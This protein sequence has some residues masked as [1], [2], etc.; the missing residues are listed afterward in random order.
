MSGGKTV[1]S[2]ANDRVRDGFGREAF[3][4]EV[5]RIPCLSRAVRE[6]DAFSQ[7]ASA[8]I[9]EAFPLMKPVYLPSA[10]IFDMDGVLID[11]QPLHFESDSLLL[12]SLG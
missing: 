4:R 5:H 11:S 9:G 7:R 8:S 6:T 2:R 3:L 12:E 1:G 10:V